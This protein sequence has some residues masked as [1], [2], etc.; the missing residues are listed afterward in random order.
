MKDIIDKLNEQKRISRSIVKYW[1]VNYVPVP[2]KSNLEGEAED[3][4]NHLEE[5]M[6]VEEEQKRKT[7]EEAVRLAEAVQNGENIDYD[8]MNDVTRSQIDKILHEKLDAIQSIVTS[9][10]NKI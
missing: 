10:G 9:G 1:N 8:G 6:S 7:I 2:E 3:I 5:M 4:L